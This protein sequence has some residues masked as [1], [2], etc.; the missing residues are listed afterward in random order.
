M[1]DSNASSR[2]VSSSKLM[3]TFLQHDKSPLKVDHEGTSD[4]EEI[5]KKEE[6]HS[7]EES[8]AEQEETKS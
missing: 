5:I 2:K 3:E 4:S 6:E 8:K 7:L 1:W